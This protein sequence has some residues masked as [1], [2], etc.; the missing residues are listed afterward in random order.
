MANQMIFQH[1]GY[2]NEASWGQSL[3]GISTWLPIVSSDLSTNVNKTLVE[4]TQTTLKG[5]DKMVRLQEEIDGTI[6]SF[7]YPKILHNFTEWVNGRE[8]TSAASGTSAIQFTYPQGTGATYLSKTIQQD[9]N[10]SQEKFSGVRATELTLSGSDS[11]IEANVTVMGRERSEGISIAPP[12]AE[13][14]KPFTF[15]KATISVGGP[16]AAGIAEVKVNSWELTYNNNMERSHQSGSRQPSRT[17]NLVPTIEG[18]LEIYHEG[19]SYVSPTFG[20]SELYVRIDLTSDSCMGNLIA[21]VT[22]VFYRVNIPRVEF[23]T[24][25]RNYEQGALS[26][27]TINFTAMYDSTTA[28]LWQVTQVVPVGFVE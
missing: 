22:P 1:L 15:D 25:E 12:V 28:S 11:L 4:D 13:V 17:D 23:T 6:N 3:A 18:S 7:A 24:N 26:V 10:N 8:G 21:G 14:F 19:V 2:E 27:E 16:A 20:C 5:R 9:R